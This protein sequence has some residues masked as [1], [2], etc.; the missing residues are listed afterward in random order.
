VEDDLLDTGLSA[1]AQTHQQNLRL[2]TIRVSNC[3][4]SNVGSRLIVSGKRRA[5]G[6]DVILLAIF[7]VFES[8]L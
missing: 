5:I 4:S 8:W 1:L 6:C 7:I 3:G 2:G